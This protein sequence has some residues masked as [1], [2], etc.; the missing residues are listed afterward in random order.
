MC[1]KAENAHAIAHAQCATSSGCL[2][3][4]A[5]AVAVDWLWLGCGCAPRC[6]QNT[7]S[8]TQKGLKHYMQCNGTLTT[9][10]R[11][12][13]SCWNS[14][15]PALAEAQHTV[16]S[17]SPHVRV[18]PILHARSAQAHCKGALAMLAGAVCSAQLQMLFF[19]RNTTAPAA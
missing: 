2:K 4:C 8:I 3:R 5:V 7:M 11:G 9:L 15:G 12:L 19:Y 17:S 10:G 6:M 18:I 13:D 1:N 16:V 14:A